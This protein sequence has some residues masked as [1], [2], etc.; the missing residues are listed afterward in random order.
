LTQ[1]CPGTP[2]ISNKEAI[3]CF[4]VTAIPTIAGLLDSRSTTDWCSPLVLLEV[5]IA[6]MKTVD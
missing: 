2:E 4:P 5:S 1:V 6:K 3:F